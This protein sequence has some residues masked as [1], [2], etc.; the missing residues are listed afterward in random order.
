M[1]IFLVP[2]LLPRS[3]W[4][5]STNNK[6]M[7]LIRL[8]INNFAAHQAQLSGGDYIKHI[9]LKRVDDTLFLNDGVHLSHSGNEI[10]LNKIAAELSRTVSA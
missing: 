5:Y 4:R 8:R 2:K 10:F 1:N 9:D 3:A 6:A 7:H